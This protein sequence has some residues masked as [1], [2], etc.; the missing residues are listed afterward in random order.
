MTG[1]ITRLVAQRRNPKRINVHV[2]GVYAAALDLSVVMQAG[3]HRGQE[4]GDEELAQ[5][6]GADSVEKAYDRALVFLSFRP[7]STAEVRRNLEGHKTPPEVIDQVVDRLK[8]GSLLDDAA[9]A[10]M[11]VE[12]RAA[13][14]PRSAR[15]LG[16]ELRQKGVGA[17]DVEAALPEDDE[18]AAV[19]GGQAEGP[20]VPQSRAER[21]PT[22][23]AGLPAEARF[24]VRGRRR[25]SEGRLGGVPG[26]VRLARTIAA[27][28]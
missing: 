12:N 15:L 3:L 17:E 2:D 14:S 7:R 11:W 6:A 24:R 8:A 13:F 20:P 22:K 19:G 26:T 5:L 9:F 23:D 18:A 4:I 27:L 1:T 28:R 16:Y 25:R 10:R 21:V